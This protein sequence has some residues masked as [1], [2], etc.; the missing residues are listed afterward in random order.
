MLIS[1]AAYNVTRESNVLILPSKRTLLDYSNWHNSQSGF[2]MEVLQELY[3]SMKVSKLS[4][5][6]RCVWCYC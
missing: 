4:E 2:Q 3:K 1:P 6:Q 5:T